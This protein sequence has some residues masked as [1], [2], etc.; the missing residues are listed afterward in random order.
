MNPG[1]EVRKNPVGTVTVVVILDSEGAIF[2]EGTIW[3]DQE[4][5]DGKAYFM[6]DEY[7]MTHY[8]E[9][10]WTVEKLRKLVK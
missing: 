6:V 8:K 2:Y 4:L 9:L 10:W 1:P 7:F 5:E 3:T